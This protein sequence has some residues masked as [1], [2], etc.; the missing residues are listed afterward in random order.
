VRKKAVVA[1][2][3]YLPFLRAAGIALKANGCC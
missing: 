1:L 2:L 3:A